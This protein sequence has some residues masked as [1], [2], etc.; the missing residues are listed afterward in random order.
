MDPV[1]VHTGS[2]HKPVPAVPV[3]PIHGG[4]GS[5]RGLPDFEKLLKSAKNLPWTMDLGPGTTVYGRRSMDHA[6]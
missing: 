6:P 4:S 5:V 1:P 2:V 3:L